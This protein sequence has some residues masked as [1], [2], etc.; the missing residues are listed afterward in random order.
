MS[1][2]LHVSCH[3]CCV[4]LLLRLVQLG[5]YVRINLWLMYLFMHA[6]T[7]IRWRFGLTAFSWFIDMCVCVCVFVRLFLFDCVCGCVCVLDFVFV[8]FGSSAGG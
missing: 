5:F 4:L 6:W 8:F 3:G 2:G 1:N 7:H